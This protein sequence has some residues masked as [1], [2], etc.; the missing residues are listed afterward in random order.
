MNSLEPFDK[1]TWGSW[2][3][4]MKHLLKTYSFFLFF[5]NLY[6]ISDKYTFNFW[7]VRK[8]LLPNSHAAQKIICIQLYINYY[9]ASENS[10]WSLYHVNLL[11]KQS[12]WIFSQIHMLVW[13]IPL[14]WALGKLRGK[15][16]DMN[17]HWIGPLGQFSHRVAMSGCLWFCLFAPSDAV[18]FE[19]SHWPWDHMISSRPLIGQPHWS[20]FFKTVGWMWNPPAP[21]YHW[22][23]P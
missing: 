5:I 11:A 13:P 1:S 7:Q 6:A 3:I 21:I 8:Q 4:H 10:I 22:I 12:I 15:Q 16:I 2:S 14:Y 17:F 19:A 9:A 23:G 18:F 20:G